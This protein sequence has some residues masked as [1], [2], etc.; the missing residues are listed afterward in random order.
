MGPQDRTAGMT[1]RELITF[2]GGFHADTEVRLSIP[3]NPVVDRHVRIDRAALAQED[4]TA[5]YYLTLSPER[6]E[7][8]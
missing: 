4:P 1:A 3:V 5:D 8:Q 2:L 7:L 6:G